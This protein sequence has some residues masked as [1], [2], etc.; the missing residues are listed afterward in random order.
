MFNGLFN[1]DQD[2]AVPQNQFSVVG[3]ISL[4]KRFTISA[5]FYSQS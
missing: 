2:Q 4:N 1:A 5:V 3:L